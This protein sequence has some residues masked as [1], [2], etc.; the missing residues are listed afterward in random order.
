MCLPHGELA[1]KTPGHVTCAESAAGQHAKLQVLCAR[2]NIQKTR[3][4][5]QDVCEGAICHKTAGCRAEAYEGIDFAHSGGDDMPAGSFGSS[6]LHTNSCH[7]G[8]DA[9]GAAVCEL[10]CLEVPLENNSSLATRRPEALPCA[11]VVGDDGFCRGAEKQNEAWDHDM[12]S[13][14][15]AQGAADCDHMAEVDTDTVGSESDHEPYPEWNVSGIDWFNVEPELYYDPVVQEF[16]DIEWATL[17]D[18]AIRQANHDAYI[19]SRA[20]AQFAGSKAQDNEC[21]DNTS[22]SARIRF[23][24]AIR[25]TTGNSLHADARHSAQATGETSASDERGRVTWQDLRNT[26]GKCSN[27]EKANHRGLKNADACTCKAK[28]KINFQELQALLDSG[29]SIKQY[30]TCAACRKPNILTFGLN[31]MPSQEDGRQIDAKELS[32]APLLKG[33]HVTQKIMKGAGPIPS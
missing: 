16:V 13:G 1:Q 14:V 3:A 11:G 8:V 28:T 21:Q 5:N 20:Y 23:Y 33:G 17:R 10:N 29:C 25:K 6:E 9:H 18:N 26:L 22:V 12:H 7:N 30:L 15:D 27:A 31:R 32:F 24:E 4:C 2:C 19:N